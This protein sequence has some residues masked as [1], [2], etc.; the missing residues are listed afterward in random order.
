[1]ENFLLR[2]GIE[3]SRCNTFS[4]A[5]VVFNWFLLV[6]W[7]KGWSKKCRSVALPPFRHILDKWFKLLIKEKSTFKKFGH[8]N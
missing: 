3:S 7:L 5:V 4:D 6:G 8:R 1:M 2:Q